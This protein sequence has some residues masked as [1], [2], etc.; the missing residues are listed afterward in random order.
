MGNKVRKTEC[1]LTASVV[2][3]VVLILCFCITTY[4]LV[5]PT[6]SVPDNIFHTGTVKINLNDGVPVIEEHEF[7]FEP[8]KTVEKDFFIE[9]QGTC[10]VY[11]KIYLSDAA[12]GL[13]DVVEIT[14]LDGERVLAS[15][16]AVELDRVNVGAADT[17][18]AVGER[19]TL[20]VRFR[21]P[22]NAGNSEQNMKLN[23][24]LCAD[25]VQTKNNP[26]RLF[27]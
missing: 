20:T 16:T 4:A 3:M 19:R 6:V 1:R 26:D 2:A 18:L 21:F 25:A 17:A 11:Y 10:D 24:N 9:N 13:S 15:G 12:G 22:E 27:G 23:F 7:L 8:G 5:M 14:V